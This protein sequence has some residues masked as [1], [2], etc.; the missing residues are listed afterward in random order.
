M[1]PGEF[2]LLGANAQNLTSSGHLTEPVAT[3]FPRLAFLSTALVAVVLFGAV[4][5]FAKDKTPQTRTVRGVTTDESDNQI[6][7]AAIQLTDLQTKKVLDVY[8]GPGGQYQ[9][10]DLRFDHDYTVKATYKNLSSETRQ[11]SSL[12]IRTP[13]EMNLV[14]LKPGK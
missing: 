6:Q 2:N 14:L 9:F 13:L 1:K 8:S 5:G 4:A 7:G 12:D 3:G 10:T 11:I